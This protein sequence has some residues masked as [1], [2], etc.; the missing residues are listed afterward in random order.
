[1]QG[2]AVSDRPDR[3]S[4]TKQGG[5][6][7]GE[8]LRRLREEIPWTQ[9]ECADRLTAGVTWSFESPV[10]YYPVTRDTYGRWERGEQ[11]PSPKALN[12]VSILFCE[13][14]TFAELRDLREAS[15]A[16]HRSAHH[17]GRASAGQ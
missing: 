2:K 4:E 17:E 7:L 14:T 3:D 9:Q 15:R 5:N 12:A 13:S 8:F 1:L 11:L 10:T 6:E 16:H